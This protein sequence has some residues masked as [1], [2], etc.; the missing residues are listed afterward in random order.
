MHLSDD[1]TR[2]LV[3]APHAD[4]EALGCGGLLARLHQR[5][6]ATHVLYLVV[7]GFRHYGYQGETTY[8]Q[9]VSEIE[10]VTKLLGCTYEIAY[11]DQGLIEKLDTLPKR[12]LVDL[13]EGALNKYRPELRLR[14]P[15]PRSSASGSSRT[16]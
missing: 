1:L 4:D 9:R 13:V 15:S 14:D 12:D 16:S 3:V 2:V 10:G 8:A 11:G 7:D 6:C 5:A